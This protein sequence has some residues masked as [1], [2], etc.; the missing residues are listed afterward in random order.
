[1]PI[2]QKERTTKKKY[3]GKERHGKA[4]CAPENFRLNGDSRAKNKRHG[5][6]IPRYEGNNV[7]PWVERDGFS[8]GWNGGI[9]GSNCGLKRKQKAERKWINQPV[10][11]RTSGVRRIAA[12]RIE[13]KKA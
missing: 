6:V 10:I 7:Y 1:M 12:I 9:F 5:H 8:H 13:T 4:S 11:G 3:I 2:N